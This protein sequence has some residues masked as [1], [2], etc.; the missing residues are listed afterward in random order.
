MPNGFLRQRISAA[1][2]RPLLPQIAKRRLERLTG[3]PY[4]KQPPS[5]E[6]P[7]IG[8]VALLDLVPRLSPKYEAPYHLEETLVAELELAIAPHEGQR[9][10]WFSVPPRHWKTETL[11][12][13]IVKHL[14]RWPE[15]AVAYFT[16]TQSFASKQSRDVRRIGERLGWR[17]AHDSNRQDEWEL[18]EGGGL[19]ARGIGAVE[20]GRGFRLI[21]IDDPIKGREEA[22][23]P[24]ERERIYNAIEDDVIT[25]LSPDG[26]AILVHTRW[27]PDD[28]IG[29]YQRHRQW[30]GKNLQALSGPEEDQP[31]L[32]HVWGFQHLDAIR[33]AN[34][35]KFDAL[36]QGR[37]RSRGT[38]RFN[39]P[40]R[41]CWPDELPRKGYRVGYGVDL[42]Y[43]AK[44]SADFSICLKLVK[45][46]D[47]RYYVVDVVRKQVQAPEFTLTLKALHSREPGPM[48]WLA[49][50]TEKGA[51]QFIQT[52]LPALR[53]EPATS[54]KFQRSEAV[55]EAW[56]QGLILVPGPSE[57]DPDAPLPEWVEDLV[58]EITNF[59]GVADAHDD[60]VDA[61]ASAFELLRFAGGHRGPEPPF[62]PLS[63][64]HDMPGRGF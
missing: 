50:G 16:H 36:Y 47:G 33:R 30:H 21:I 51:A 25:R 4:P 55:A 26:T 49:S 52:K 39:E 8:D 48:L 1:S 7:G 6:L 22:N 31:L 45:G 62:V 38:K 14:A 23:S 59:T 20:S 37:P 12:H 64:W 19:L 5:T 29:R 34:V 3:T 28:P 24:I 60:Q 15:E 35:Y 63:R 40:A 41:Y 57:E 42:A 53:V 18:L 56:N 10:Y 58:D 54:D 46:D 11:K 61:L 43:T 27:H 2:A 9:F 32:P 17:F 44:T 13:G